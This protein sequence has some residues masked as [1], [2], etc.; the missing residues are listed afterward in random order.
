MQDKRG[1]S[2]L[3]KIYALWSRPFSAPGCRAVMPAEAY[4]RIR[5]MSKAGR[6]TGS[7]IEPLAWASKFRSEGRRTDSLGISEAHNLEGFPGLSFVQTMR[8]THL[9][10]RSRRLDR[11]L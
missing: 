8:S 9:V 5:W 7:R 2:G 6:A 1:D 11:L 3:D 10:N 4:I